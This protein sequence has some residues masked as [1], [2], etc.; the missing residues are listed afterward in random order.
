[1]I[2]SPV[3]GTYFYSR[4]P[5]VLVPGNQMAVHNYL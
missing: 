5:E 4:V 2:G 3:K 1:M